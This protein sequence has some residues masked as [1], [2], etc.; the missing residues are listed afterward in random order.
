[1]CRT[2]TKEESQ[3]LCSRCGAVANPTDSW[4]N[5]WPNYGH[6]VIGFCGT[7]QDVLLHRVPGTPDEKEKMVYALFNCKHPALSHKSCTYAQKVDIEWA[8]YNKYPGK[9]NTKYRLCRPCQKE[10]LEIIGEF[11]FNNTPQEQPIKAGVLSG[12]GG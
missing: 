11:F 5:D 3:V 10:L 6:I 12:K 2:L 9:M 1:M 8:A 4:E 7:I